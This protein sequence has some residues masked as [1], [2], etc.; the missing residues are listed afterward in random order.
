MSCSTDE[1][2]GTFMSKCSCIFMHVIAITQ[3]ASSSTLY[4]LYMR[5]SVEG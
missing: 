2:E 1:P 5:A 3:L 4:I